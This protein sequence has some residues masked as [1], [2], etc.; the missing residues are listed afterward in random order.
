MEISVVEYLIFCG[1]SERFVTLL[2]AD[3]GGKNDTCELS[4]IH[5]VVR[6]RQEAR[7]AKINN[8][9]HTKLALRGSAEKRLLSS[10]YFSL[11]LRTCFAY[12]EKS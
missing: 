2:M 11:F 3:N 4:I 12:G 8:K 10:F 9:I 7:A 5:I 6:R 1:S